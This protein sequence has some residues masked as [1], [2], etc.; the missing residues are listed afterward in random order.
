VSDPTT[1]EAL[2][3]ALANAVRE[4]ASIL[5]EHQVNGVVLTVRMALDQLGY[6]PAHE[7]ASEIITSVMGPSE[8]LRDGATCRD[9]T[10]SI[11]AA[12][13][14]PTEEPKP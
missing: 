7:V 6:R 2:E 4:S 9:I 13:P 10:A 1:R 5:N 11:R 12:F 8:N 14:A 3:V